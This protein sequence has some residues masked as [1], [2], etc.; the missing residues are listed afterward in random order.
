MSFLGF[1]LIIILVFVGVV[2]AVIARAVAS[3]MRLRRS[4]REAFGGAR[5]PR[6]ETDPRRR[7]GRGAEEERRKK[8]IGRDVGEYVEFEEVACTVSTDDG[9]KKESYT[10][11]EQQVTDVEW[12]DVK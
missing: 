3:V 8:K 1:I 11:T 7:R 12:E 10:A 5:Q 2:L 4:F 6:Q 9:A